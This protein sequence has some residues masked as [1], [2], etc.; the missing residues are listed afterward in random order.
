MSDAVETSAPDNAFSRPFAEVEE[1]WLSS[2]DDDDVF[3]LAE[4]LSTAVKRAFESEKESLAIQVLCGLYALG[5]LGPGCI[6]VETLEPVLFGVLP[7]HAIV[8]PQ[9]ADPILEHLVEALPFLSDEGLLAAANEEGVRS[10]LGGEG[11]SERLKEAL[12]NAD[13]YDDEKR[14]LVEEELERE[15]MRKAAEKIVKEKAKAKKKAKSKVAKASRRK[16]R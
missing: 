9:E 2:L 4:R 1:R 6:T 14:E 12:G 5:E 7:R 10:Y 16:N 15:Q 8:A 3:A 13:L 11:M